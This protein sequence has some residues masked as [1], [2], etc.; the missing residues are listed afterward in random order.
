MQVGPQRFEHRPVESEY[1][2]VRGA[3]ARLERAMEI[4][5]V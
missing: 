1:M 3:L 5:T 2:K 4:D